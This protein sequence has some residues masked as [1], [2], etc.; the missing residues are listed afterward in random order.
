M[1][2]VETRAF[3]AQSLSHPRVH[4]Q[5]RDGKASARCQRWQ[6]RST[7]GRAG[8]PRVG[9]NGGLAI[10][11]ETTFCRRITISS[12]ARPGREAGC[13]P[14]SNADNPVP[15]H[16]VYQQLPALRHNLPGASLTGDFLIS[17]ESSHALTLDPLSQL[18]FYVIDAFLICAFL[19]RSGNQP[20][21]RRTILSRRRLV[22]APNIAHSPAP[23]SLAA[24]SSPRPSV[25]VAAR[26]RLY[27]APALVKHWQ[28]PLA[29]P[30]RA[31]L[32][33]PE[34]T[35]ALFPPAAHTTTRQRQGSQDPA[36]DGPWTSGA[37]GPRKEPGFR[38][39]ITAS[40]FWAQAKQ[41]GHESAVLLRADPGRAGRPMTRNDLPNRCRPVEPG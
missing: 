25:R 3:A 23:D 32:S 38:E 31:G 20:R 12:P 22:T 2:R 16:A 40:Q 29:H 4:G 1:T 14:S 18:P 35:Q 8:T 15:S 21:E 7:N 34:S 28:H 39:I 17:R 10:S 6:R 30:P 5:A 24:I 13:S 37:A 27:T 9:H 33:S 36:G 26:R 19:V 11:D 41:A